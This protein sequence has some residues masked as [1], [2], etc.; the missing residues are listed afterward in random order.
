MKNKYFAVTAKC[1]HV[2]RHRYYEGTFYVIAT[3]AKQ[4][5][6]IVRNLPRVKHHHKDAIL[7]VVEISHDEFKAGQAEFENNPYHKCESKWQQRLVWDRILPFLRPETDLQIEH[8]CAERKVDKL[9]AYTK[10]KTKKPYKRE[11]FICEIEEV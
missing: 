2:G 9:P 1:G 3:D 4:A 10:P 6:A 7:K 11:R 8:R 5:G